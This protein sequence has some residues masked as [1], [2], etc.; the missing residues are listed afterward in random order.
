MTMP[1]LKITGLHLVSYRSIKC[2]DLPEDGIGWSG[3]I[4]DIMLVGGANGSGKTTL[5]EGLFS[6]FAGIDHNRLPEGSVFPGVQELRLDLSVCT[7]ALGALSLRLAFGDADFLKAQASQTCYAI[8]VKGETHVPDVW[9]EF[10]KGAAKPIHGQGPHVLL[11]PSERLNFFASIK[12][13]ESPDENAMAWRFKPAEKYGLSDL[14]SG[15]KHVLIFTDELRR[16][17]SPGS[18]VLIDEP[19][20]HLHTAWQSTLFRLICDLQRERGGQAIL[21]TQ[22]NHLFGLAEPGSAVVLRKD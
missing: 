9:R 2:L 3:K 5:L 17:W 4:P 11:F 16:R 12:A 7:S 14:S 6:A 8:D 22:S 10:L 21:A 13:S 20:L 15:E 19:E 18:L 1:H